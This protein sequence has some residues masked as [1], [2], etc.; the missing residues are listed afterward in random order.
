VHGA[1]GSV[2]LRAG[3]VPHYAGA[4][5]VALGR[6][7][8]IITKYN[9]A[10]AFVTAALEAIGRNVETRPAQLSTT[11]EFTEA[12]GEI[13]EPRLA[14]EG[15]PIISADLASLQGQAVYFAPLTPNDIGADC[16]EAARRAGKQVYLDAQG[17]TRR[18]PTE[19]N[20]KA[21]HAILSLVDVVKVTSAEALWLFGTDQPDDIQAAF[22]QLG[23]K[24][25]A[26]TIGSRGS[27]V[28]SPDGVA[29]IVEQPIA[30][31]DKVGCG[32]VYF[33]SYID[34]RLRGH[35]AALAGQHASAFV[36]RW[37]RQRSAA[38]S[39]AELALLEDSAS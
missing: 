37:L 38:S 10:D 24:E 19:R 1:D 25:I 16:F 34:A 8:H 29:H 15:D 12:D 3:G 5:F 22:G 33:A 26:L 4:T 9:P 36:S 32:D 28:I 14:V 2:L 21:A 13:G 23:V 18:D 6:S 39:E 30:A 7:C 31:T 35:P 17:I 20:R 27:I 11:F